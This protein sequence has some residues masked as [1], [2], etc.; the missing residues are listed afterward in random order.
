[1]AKKNWIYIKRGL[2]EDAKHRAAMGECIW[3]FLHI[4]DRADW[5]MGIAYDWKD[6]QE[7]ADM[8]M[9]VRTLRE[10]R[11]K[12]DELNYISCKQRQY[13]QDI[14]IKNWTNPRDYSGKVLNQGGSETEPE[15]YTQGY[16]QGSSQDVTPTSDSLSKSLTDSTK[17]TAYRRGEQ[18][19]PDKI[20]IL[21]DMEK[22]SIGA[23]RLYKADALLSRWSVAFLVKTTSKDW[24]KF[25]EYAVEMQ[26]K[27]GW[28]PDKFIEWVKKQEGYPTYWSQKRMEENY[29]KAFMQN[30]EPE[31][32]RDRSH[33]L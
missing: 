3:L 30:D 31:D 11:R 29:M 7:A 9:P 24:R 27:N 12:L 26:T 32:W 13:G 22:N 15:G 14:I 28:E 6:E 10:Q 5:E 8:G 16:T 18:E 17:N 4:I 21:L 2:S 33:A 20:G 25:A 19:A 23:Q 1:M